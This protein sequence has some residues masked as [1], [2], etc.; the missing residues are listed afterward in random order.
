MRALDDAGTAEA[1]RAASDRPIGYSER[2]RLLL[3]DDVAVVVVDGH[4]GIT[5]HT[6][7]QLV[8][9]LR[10]TNSSLNVT[11]ESRL[12]AA[13]ET[14]SLWQLSALLSASVAGA[15]LVVPSD[16]SG[17]LA[18]ELLD[19]WVTHGFLPSSSAQSIADVDFEDLEAVVL[20]DDAS[21]AVEVGDIVVHTGVQP[22]GRMGQS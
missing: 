21:E 4:G 20:V 6:H 3:S 2:A 5:E 22:L 18:D 17:R 16:D 11:F 19:G 12:F 10:T 9:A 15:A 13:A 8:S 14:T 1:V 7:G